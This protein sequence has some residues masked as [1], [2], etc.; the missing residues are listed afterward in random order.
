[1]HVRRIQKIDT[2][3]MLNSVKGVTELQSLYTLFS[4]V[5]CILSNPNLQYSI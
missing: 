2:N 5:K 1:M 4:G 3:N